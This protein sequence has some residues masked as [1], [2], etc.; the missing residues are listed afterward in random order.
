MKKSLTGAVALLAG[1]FVAHSQGTVQF[2]NYLKL[3]SYI[4]VYSAPTSGTELS[5]NS[6]NYAAAGSVP[7]GG[8]GTGATSSTDFANGSL[9]TV[10]LWGAA[11]A[12]QTTGLAPLAGLTTTLATGAPNDS[13]AGTW[14][15]SASAGVPGTSFAGDVATVQVYAWYNAD[16]LY[17]SYAAAIAG[18][19]PHGSSDLANVTLGGPP[20]PAV[21]GTPTVA[22]PLPTGAN[23]IQDFSLGSVPE[24]STIALGVMGASAFLLRLRR[25]S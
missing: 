4:Y 21:G 19:A 25:K 3:S 18:G 14:A 24:P 15:T 11:G 8:T 7:L 17:T 6:V 9:Y 16:G 13:T 22:A 20:N 5:G 10:Q 2:A 12:N 1:A 23:G